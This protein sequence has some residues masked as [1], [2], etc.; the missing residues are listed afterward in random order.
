MKTVRSRTLAALGVALVMLLLLVPMA[1]A[2][3]P[4]PPA[5]GI[6]LTPLFQAVIATLAALVTVKLIPWIKRR[7]TAEQQTALNLVTRTLV[8]AAEQIFRNEKESGNKKLRYVKAKLRQKGYDIDLDAIEAAVMALKLEE[9]WVIETA[10]EVIFD[11]MK[12]PDG[13]GEQK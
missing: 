10:S 5:L 3:E 6:D 9:S 7:T 1:F 13:A 8:Y 12:P 2:E 4:S 11:E